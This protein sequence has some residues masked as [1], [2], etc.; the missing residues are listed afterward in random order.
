[1]RLLCFLAT[2]AI[3]LAQPAPPVP[4]WDAYRFLL[5]EWVGVGGG[6]PGEATAGGFSFRLDLGDRVLIRH[7]TSDYPAH[8]GRP[9]AHHE[10][11]MVV[12][13]AGRASYWDNEGHVIAYAVE[14]A[15]GRWRFLSPATP[16]AP[17]F[18]QTYTKTGPDAVKID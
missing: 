2:C 5:G 1:M 9:A 8:D 3:A 4:T 11:L 13:P 6:K 15:E 12:E 17:R 14:A 16:G 7:N 10:D 18:R